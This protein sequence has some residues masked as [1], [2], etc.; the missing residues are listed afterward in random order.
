MCVWLVYG[1]NAIPPS[2]PRPSHGE[3]FDGQLLDFV[4]IRLGTQIQNLKPNYHLK[5]Y[6]SEESAW[7]RRVCQ[8]PP[9]PSSH[10]I[11]CSNPCAYHLPITSRL[12]SSNPVPTLQSRS[13]SQSRPLLTAVNF[14][15][16]VAACVAGVPA[17]ASPAGL[18][19]P[20]LKNV[21]RYTMQATNN[22]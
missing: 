3:G 21:R 1:H 11:A 8:R 9:Q 6:I 17:Q 19:W 7:H 13:L 5:L 20:R 18:Q 2:K 10:H 4:V 22:H 14:C 16:C 15:D 12:P